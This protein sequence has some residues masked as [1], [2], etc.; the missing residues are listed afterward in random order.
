MGAYLQRAGPEQLMRARLQHR[1]P[2]RSAL[3]AAGFSRRAGGLPV[4]VPEPV[5]LHEGIQQGYTPKTLQGAS[6]STSPA[7]TR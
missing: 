5:G 7:S 1:L 3:A 6:S 4:N 2:G